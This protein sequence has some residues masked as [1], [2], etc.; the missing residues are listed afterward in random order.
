MSTRRKSR[1]TY[2]REM[3][4]LVAQMKAQDEKLTK[5]LVSGIMTDEVCDKLDGYKDSEIRQIGQL[6]AADI[7]IYVARYEDGKK[8]TPADP[9]PEQQEPQNNPMTFIQH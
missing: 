1:E 6:I 8:K 3:E 4:A 2:K 7:D 5:A 9:E